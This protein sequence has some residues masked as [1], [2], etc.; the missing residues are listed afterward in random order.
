MLAFSGKQKKTNPSWKMDAVRPGGVLSKE[1][2][3][4]VTAVLGYLV[5]LRVDKLAA[6]MI[7]TA[8]NGTAER[9]LFNPMLVKKGKEVLKRVKS[10]VC[11]GA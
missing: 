8:L 4:F 3:G 6:A 2:G 5:W 9:R 1:R 7:E 10:R 11:I